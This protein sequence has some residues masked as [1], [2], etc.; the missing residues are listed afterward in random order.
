MGSRPELRASPARVNTRQEVLA[1]LERNGAM[2]FTS[3]E[4][5]ADEA[6]AN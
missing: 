3:A 2:L 4:S 1:Y 6:A 5:K